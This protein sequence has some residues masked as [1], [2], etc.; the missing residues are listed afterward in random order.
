MNFVTS[1]GSIESFCIPGS[2]RTGFWDGMYD[3]FV[4]ILAFLRCVLILLR[5]HILW[6]ALNLLSS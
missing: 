6:L 5:N 2:G 3:E 4:G 1:I